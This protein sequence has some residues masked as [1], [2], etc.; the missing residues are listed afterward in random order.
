M[1][2]VKSDLF[3]AEVNGSAYGGKAKFVGGFP[4]IELE[5]RECNEKYGKEDNSRQSEPSQKRSVFTLKNPHHFPARGFVSNADRQGNAI[6]R[7]SNL[8]PNFNDIWIC[9]NCNAN[10]G[11][12]TL[13][14]GTVAGKTSLSSHKPFHTRLNPFVSV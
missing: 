3:S 5:S 2:A 14:D 6:L 11:S 12:R 7:Y 1:R 13:L 8:R 10:T 4:P 9:D